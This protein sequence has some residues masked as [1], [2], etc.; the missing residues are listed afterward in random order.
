MRERSGRKYLPCWRGTRR[1]V[2]ELK[3]TANPRRV[4]GKEFAGAKRTKIPSVLEGHKEGSR[5]TKKN[6]GSPK[7]AREGIC[8]SE[9]DENTFRAG[10]ALGGESRNLK[11]QRIPGEC[12]GRNLR[13]RSGRKC[14]PRWRG[15][16]RGVAEL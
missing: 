5:G 9:A 2:A 1:G 3:K 14:L 10:G 4:P 16:R 6:S 7:S 8:G 15:T 11:K 13:E 12:P